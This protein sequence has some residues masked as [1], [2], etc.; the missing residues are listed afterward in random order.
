[1]GVDGA[2]AELADLVESLGP[3]G[4]GNAEP[5][6]CLQN[7]QIAFADTVGESHVRCRIGGLGQGK[8]AHRWG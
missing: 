5:R 6:F 8:Q 2:N 7:A 4:P 1:M 3:Y